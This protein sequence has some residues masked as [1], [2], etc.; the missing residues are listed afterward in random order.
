MHPLGFVGMGCEPCL[1]VAAA[2][3]RQLGVDVGV[4]FVLGDGNLAVGHG[5]RLCPGSIE[6]C[7]SAALPFPA[8]KGAKNRGGS[9]SFIASIF[10]ASIFASTCISLPSL[11]APE[12]GSFALERGF[13]MGARAGEA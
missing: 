2:L 4:Q 9:N 6:N 11:N 7:L 8:G 5:R 10:F 3:P 1:D 13:D 12:R